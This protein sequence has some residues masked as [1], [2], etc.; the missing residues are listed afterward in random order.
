MHCALTMLVFT[1]MITPIEVKH[2]HMRDLAAKIHKGA[3]DFLITEYKFLTVFVLAIFVAV[4]CMLTTCSDPTN[5]RQPL[6]PVH[7]RPAARW[8][9]ALGVRGLAW[10]EDRH[11]RQRAHAGLR[12]GHRRLDQGLRVASSRAPSW[13]L[14]SL[15]SASSA[16]RSCT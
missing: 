10:H 2:P 13:V 8:C 7:R 6:R 3:V 11:A 12:P 16:S 4:S 14:A 5:R 1:Y 15:A 9:D